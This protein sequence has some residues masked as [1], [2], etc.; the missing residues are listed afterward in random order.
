M[1]PKPGSSP[2]KAETQSTPKAEGAGDEFVSWLNSDAG[3]DEIDKMEGRRLRKA[4]K[5]AINESKDDASDDDL[6][7]GAGG[8]RKEEGEGEG[9]GERKGNGEESEEEGGGGHR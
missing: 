3:A 4:M 1:P 8:E 2:V 6:A 5:E 7:E 9:D